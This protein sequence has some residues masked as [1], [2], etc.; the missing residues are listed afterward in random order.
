MAFPNPANPNTTIR[1]AIERAGNLKLTIYDASGRMV[2]TLV[3]EFAGPGRGEA[4]W[5][6]RDG[7]GNPAPSGVYTYRIDA[8]GFRETD[9]VVLLR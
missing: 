2:R 4:T 9:R 1:Y 6:G 7:Q 5:D 3:D 8:A